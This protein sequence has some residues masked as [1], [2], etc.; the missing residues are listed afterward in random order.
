MKNNLT[1]EILLNNP[2][3]ELIEEI[4][5]DDIKQFLIKEIG[6]KT[7]L[8]TFFGILQGIA[9]GILFGLIAYFTTVLIKEGTHKSDLIITL[10]SIFLSVIFLIPVHELIHAAAFLLLGKKDIGFGAQWK[11]FVFYAES[12]MQVLDRKEI[13]IVA[14]APLFLI[15]VISIFLI[16]L[17][18]P[19]P[20]KLVFTVMASVHLLFCG[21]DIAIVSFFN[22]N[23]SNEL[24]TF[25]N[26]DL[27]KSYFF[28]R[29]KLLIH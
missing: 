15:T 12:N 17:P 28:S 22:R 14:L 26:R 8:M 1:P 16:L 21:G 2:E 10:S 19:L 25:D 20:I 6:K 18:T 29:S 11:K 3:F 9:I 5:Y 27:K 23:K 24:F 4:H 13:T 7:L